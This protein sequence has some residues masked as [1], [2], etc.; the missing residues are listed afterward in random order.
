MSRVKKLYKQKSAKGKNLSRRATK[1]LN[2]KPGLYLSHAMGYLKTLDL[3]KQL[4]EHM[5]G[6][7]NLAE[8]HH[9]V[10]NNYYPY[11]LVDIM[12]EVEEWALFAVYNIIKTLT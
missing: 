6:R 8:F 4:S 10:A 3:K 1:D 2:N 7:F 11:D 5:K 9:R 12:S